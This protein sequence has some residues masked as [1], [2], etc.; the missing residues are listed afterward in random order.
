MEKRYFFWLGMMDH[1]FYFVKWSAERIQDPGSR[2]Q[3]KSGGYRHLLI[4]ND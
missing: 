3:H 1:F 2:S 4:N